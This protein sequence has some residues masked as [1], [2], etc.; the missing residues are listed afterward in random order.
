MER[1]SFTHENKH[2]YQSVQWYQLV[3][4]KYFAELVANKPFSIVSTHSQLLLQLDIRP[5]LLIR[6]ST[7]HQKEQFS[8]CTRLIN[9]G[10]VSCL[11]STPLTQPASLYKSLAVLKPFSSLS[12][13]TTGNPLEEFICEGQWNKES[14]KFRQGEC[15][16][17]AKLEIMAKITQ[18][19]GTP[20]P[21]HQQLLR[22]QPL[23]SDLSRNHQ[24]NS[25][26]S[27]PHHHLRKYSFE[28]REPSPCTTNNHSPRSAY[29]ESNITLPSARSVPRTGGCR[30]E[31]ALA[32]IKRR[33]PYSMGS[34]KLENI[35]LSSIKNRLTPEEEQRL[36]SDIEILYQQ[37][38]PSSECELRRRRLVHKLE[39]LF[40][41]KWPGHNTLVH[42]FG[43]SGNW[44]YTDH[45]DVDLCITTDKKEMEGVCIIAD[46]LANN[47]MQ[48]VICVSTAKVPI[49]KI[50]DPEL[51]LACDMNVNNTLALE[52]TRMIK[53]YVEI[54]ERV[55]PL[56]MIIKHWTKR[57][58]VNDAAFGGT[59]SSYTWICMII[60]FLQSR[61]PPILPALH[62]RAKMKLPPENGIESAFADDID[63]LRNFGHKNKETLGELLFSFFR[64]YAHEFD[65]D[66][67]VISVRQGKQIS[68][69]E[70]GWHLTNNNRLCVEEPFNVG[71]N[72]GNTVDDTSFRGLHI[73][74]RRAFDLISQAKLKECCEQ[75]IFPPEE[76]RKAWEPAIK[77]KVVLR[78]AST[79]RAGRGGNHRLNRTSSQQHRHINNSRRASSGTF[80]GNFLQSHPPHNLL[81]QET[82]LHRQAQAQ[83]QND[84]YSTYSA[85]Q[86]H[87]NNLRIQLY[88]HGLKSQAYAQTQPQKQPSNT[89]IMKPSTPEHPR[90]SSFDQSS[91][92][93][94]PPPQDMLYYP[95]HYAEN[96][97][98]NYPK[99]NKCPTSSLPEQVR[100]EIRS[101]HR[102]SSRSVTG[103]P[104]PS[105]N[106]CLRSHSQPATRTELPQE[107]SLNTKIALTSSTNTEQGY[108]RPGNVSPVANLI[109]D[110]IH[111]SVAVSATPTEKFEPMEYVGYYVRENYPSSVLGE[112][113]MPI[114][115]QNFVNMIQPKRRHSTDQIVK[116]TENNEMRPSRSQS[117]L[118]QDKY[119]PITIRSFPIARIPAC[120]NM[121]RSITGVVSPHLMSIVKEP[122]PM[123]VSAI[124]WQAQ[125]NESHTYDQSTTKF[126]TGLDDSSGNIS[127]TQKSLVLTREIPESLS[128]KQA[129]NF[130]VND[131]II[132]SDS[133]TTGNINGYPA[134][135]SKNTSI[136]SSLVPFSNNIP[137]YQPLHEVSN[138]YHNKSLTH[139]RNKRSGSSQSNIISPIDS[140]NCTLKDD[141]PILSPVLEIQNKSSE[142]NQKPYTCLE[143]KEGNEIK[144]RSE[145]KSTMSLTLDFKSMNSDSHFLPVSKKQTQISKSESDG[146]GN[147]QQVL[148]GKKKN[149]G[150]ISKSLVNTR[151]QG[152]AL[153]TNASE[154]KGG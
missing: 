152:E 147:W 122:S 117:P 29:S 127:Y 137:N 79:I 135:T 140:G 12:R 101:I 6:K 47:G 67:L 115:T 69:V 138:D 97:S 104:E 123:P 94:T 131:R 148:R 43:S 17:V 36:S 18:E 41:N 116:T 68:K 111:R 83:L 5:S 134:A 93:T 51:C 59:I 39:K 49:V 126:L 66:S 89:R 119:D 88:A 85:L 143:R 87:E 63:A 78:N 153:P 8:H 102:S 108:S 16:P 107:G 14:S 86:A 20:N 130:T 64:F 61:S 91:S 106:S 154:R 75:W 60:N 100:P 121:P 136:Y 45:S 92:F 76:E 24:S 95:S 124:A 52:N 44:L 26:P 56:A 42:V 25:V 53:T 73:E 32:N 31:T 77:T 40:N 103:N 22:T 118:L 65:Y 2:Q 1:Q 82:W 57:R 110:D 120:P 132:T 128:M 23:H 133:S 30:Y 33:M 35:N 46:L 114:V 113:K 4:H 13:S 98:Y 37:I 71:R 144:S 15:M 50:W 58:I 28:S 150:S 72:L 7:S 10:R 48:N 81:P 62:Q 141:L 38:L 142:G 11:V 9:S 70:K 34:E 151:G 145:E 90:P 3:P 149:S 139:S 55:R 27:T 21:P 99:P 74:M 105:T 19:I 112:D 146:L 54:D 125:L 96:P 109:S 129:P 80:D 84:L